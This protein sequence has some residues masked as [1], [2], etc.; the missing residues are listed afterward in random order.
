MKRPPRINPISIEQ[1]LER[2]YKI[3]NTPHSKT[4]KLVKSNCRT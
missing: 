1:A 2:L 4:D 3:I